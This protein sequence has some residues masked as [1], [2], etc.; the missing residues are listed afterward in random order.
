MRGAGVDEPAHSDDAAHP[1][2]AAAAVPPARVKRRPSRPGE[3][4]QAAVA[5]FNERG[6]QGTNM[7]DIGAAVGI[8]GPGIYRHFP[9]KQAILETALVDAGD[10]LMA[11]IQ[12][13][14][15]AGDPPDRTLD[16]L[17][18]NYLDGVLE[19]P[20]LSVLV[21]QD[22]GVLSDTMREWGADH[23]RVHM[24]AWVDALSASRPEL[25]RL[26]CRARVIGAFSMAYAMPP[27]RLLMTR[28]QVAGNLRAMC[29]AILRA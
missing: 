13:I 29:A 14:V 24:R 10:R 20:A 27:L 4:L 15:G 19:A 11:G 23:L 22:E 1:A 16:R 7:A 2:A 3:I 17:V 9:S 26:E 12:A 8:T 6:Y 28:E 18:E 5:L 21:L 25:T